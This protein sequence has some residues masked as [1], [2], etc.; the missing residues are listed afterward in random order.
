M[1]SAGLVIAA[2]RRHFD[3]ALDTG[4]TV[5]CVIKGRSLRIAAGDRVEI[6]RAATGDVIVA[7]APRINL[8]YR[9]DAFK[10][11]F[12]A[13]N[14]T[15]V[16][17][18]VAP[19]V[20][21]DEEL[22]NRWMIAAEAA[23]CRYVVLA[24]KSDLPSFPGLRTRLAPYEALGYDVV[25]MSAKHGADA[26]APWLADQHTVLVGQSG[27]G[28]STLINSLV[29]DANVRTMQISDAL[30]AGRHTTTSTTLYR[31]PSIGAD[32]WIVDSPGVKVFGLAHVEGDALAHAFVE[33]RPFLG[34]CRFR[35]CRHDAEPGCAITAAVAEGRVA[36]HRLALLHTLQNENARR[37]R[38]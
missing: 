33:L 14:V 28:K 17:A 20:S 24:N 37:L 23:R 8:V 26:A 22:V 12:L 13:A 4:E 3:V 21:L 27:M 10:D 1:T 2:Y 18:V 25:A 16:A 15:Q 34:H 6:E 11:K 38:Y 36:P 7:V 32:T 5:A 31:V 30:N 19:D 29:P 9:S 35:D